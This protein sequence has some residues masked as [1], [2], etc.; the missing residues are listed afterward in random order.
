MARGLPSL[1]VFTLAIGLGACSSQVRHQVLSTLFDGVPPPEGT[2]APLAVAHSETGELL[3]GDEPLTPP[4]SHPPFRERNCAA[5]HQTGS[6]R[7]L[8]SA[9]QLYCLKCHDGETAPDPTRGLTWVHG[10]VSAV[11]CLQC[12]HPHESR[13]PHLVKA[14]GA[15]VCT[16]CHVEKAADPRRVA[17]GRGPPT[18]PSCLDCHSPHGG[19]TRFML[20]R[21]SVK[22][23]MGVE[24]QQEEPAE[25]VKAPL[26]ADCHDGRTAPNPLE[27]LKWL[28]GPVAAGDCLT[29]HQ[30]H[31]P[32]GRTAFLRRSGDAL[33]T[34]CHDN[35][36]PTP[37]RAH[38]KLGQVSCLECHEAHGGAVRA[39]PR[40]PK[41]QRSQGPPLGGPTEAP[42]PESTTDPAAPSDS[43]R[44]ES[45][46]SAPQ[47]GGDR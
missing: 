32:T 16:A 34:E 46:N 4:S 13:F 20:H 23:Y 40:A 18:W 30:P 36:A 31:H 42:A 25:L 28:H 19:E 14:P 27:G 9:P 21:G 22:T 35:L 45:T 2:E 39:M 33:C 3:V 43:E 5:C 11:E 24:R 7:A 15:A 1:L 6:L 44:S 17:T 41:G 38:S 26:C 47:T 8:R 29:C 12:H 37:G 10:P